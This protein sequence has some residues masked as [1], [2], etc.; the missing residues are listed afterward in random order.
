LRVPDDLGKSKVGDLDLSDTTGTN[1][2]YEFT[3][4]SLV[5]LVG[6]FGFRIPSRNKWYWIKKKILR[7]DISVSCQ[8][9]SI[10]PVS[11]VDAPM[12]NTAFFMQVK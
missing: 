3:F 4:I 2:G 11:K 10:Y 5:L 6:S 8:H 1:A 7:L 9:D 12:N